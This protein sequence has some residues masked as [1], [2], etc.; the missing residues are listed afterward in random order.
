MPAAL[1]T[2]A[3]GGIGRAVAERLLADG[4]D[5]LAVDINADAAPPAAIPSTLIIDRQGR[6]AAI[7]LGAVV[8]TALEP[9]V[10]QLAAE[11]KSG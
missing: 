5:V 1:V 9:V 7:A 4:A 2:G 3:A 8:Q 11:S 10:D 6:I